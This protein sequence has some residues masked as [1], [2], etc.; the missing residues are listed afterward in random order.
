M[1]FIE[2]ISEFAPKPMVEAVENAYNRIFKG[3]MFEA[4]SPNWIKRHEMDEARKAFACNMM[5]RTELDWES[6]R[7]AQ[8][9][10][11]CNE[12]LTRPAAEH[13]ADIGQRMGG[14]VMGNDVGDYD[15]ENFTSQAGNPLTVANIILNDIRKKF[16]KFTGAPDDYRP[17]V[18]RIA[19]LL[20][21]LGGCGISWPQ[22][23]FR[24]IKLLQQFMRYVAEVCPD[25]SAEGAQFDPF[26]NG[27]DIE[28][29]REEYGEEIMRRTVARRA[30]VDAYLPA[31][32]KDDYDIVL[33]PDFQ[34]ARQYSRYV[35]W[36]TVRQ[37]MAWDSFT[38]EGINNMYFCLKHGFETVPREAGEN[39]PLDDYGLSMIA[40]VVDP[41]GDMLACCSRWNDANGGSDS[42]MS[43][44][45][46]S[47]V[48][49]KP[50]SEAF[51]Y[52][53][54]GRQGQLD[55]IT[56]SAGGQQG[57]NDDDDADADAAE[58]GFD[59]DDDDNGGF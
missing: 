1:D 31:E 33:I 12:L 34:T 14:N 59:D 4:F 58:L 22:Q 30:E 17:G 19:M 27:L 57:Y 5:G 2:F 42:C 24:N 54:N 35:P 56:G 38:Q 53:E 29:I 26:L 7:V 46:L 18:T 49:G 45:Q 28:D 10:Q 8:I 43:E 50:F 13:V 36:C 11:R 44:E 15:A 39:T 25:P 37:K 32:E 52:V 51:P 16:I 47:E 55:R 3:P 48:I 41:D 40:V 6:D 23:S 20:P 9:V 21:S